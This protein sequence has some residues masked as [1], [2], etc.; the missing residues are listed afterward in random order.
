[1]INGNGGGLTNLN[2][3]QL[4]GALPAIS[5]ASLTSLPANVA[6][7]TASSQTFTGRNSFNQGIGVNTAS[8]LEG[9][10]IINT[11]TYV[12]SHIIYLRGETGT[13]HNHGLAYNGNSITNFGTG[14]VQV[15]GPVLWGFSGGALGVMNGGAHAVLTW[16]NAGVLINGGFAFSS[17]RNLKGRF[18]PL[19]PQD[20]LA[21]VAALPV[22][23]WVYTNNVGARHIGPMAQDFHAAFQ[24]NGDDDKHINVGD[25]T[26]VALAAIQGLNQKLE[27]DSQSSEAK[28]QKLEAENTK[29]KARLDRLEQLLAGGAK[30]AE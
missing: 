30:G 23:S 10:V 21:R 1:M 13:D 6:L 24:M 2:A 8:A 3:A 4:T 28:I 27:A 17:D 7:L 29:L 19:N 16:T 5:G 11:N 26:G 25:E 18:A 14:N 12:F 20:V 15:D 22:T 9:D